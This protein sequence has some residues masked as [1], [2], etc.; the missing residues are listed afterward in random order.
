MCVSCSVCICIAQS[1]CG[2]GQC[3]NGE[4]VATCFRDCAGVRRYQCPFNAS[5]WL[6]PGTASISVLSPPPSLLLLTGLL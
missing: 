6:Q 5:T 4:D 3:E 1:T 2:N